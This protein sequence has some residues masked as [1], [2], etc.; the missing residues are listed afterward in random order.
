VPLLGLDEL[1][2]YATL[3]RKF[4]K[5]T[6][7]NLRRQKKSQTVSDQSSK[8]LRGSRH[9]PAKLRTLSPQIRTTELLSLEQKLAKIAK[10]SCG[11]L[12]IRESLTPES[13]RFLFVYRPALRKVRTLSAQSEAMFSAEILSTLSIESPQSKIQTSSGK[14][15]RHRLRNLQPKPKRATVAR[16]KAITI[17]LLA[18]APSLWLCQAQMWRV[19]LSVFQREGG[20]S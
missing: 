19:F 16:R 12:Q 20:A 8:R 1:R 5:P 6:A 9:P 10:H 17:L 11:I 7:T 3:S 18:H 4:H 2:N 14:S 15:R 13:R